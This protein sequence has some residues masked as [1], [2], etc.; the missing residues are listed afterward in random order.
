MRDAAGTTAMPATM[1]GLGW[2]GGPWWGMDVRR[3]PTFWVCLGHYIFLQVL[4]G[5]ALPRRYGRF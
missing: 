2:P 1:W 3:R 4:V 5:V